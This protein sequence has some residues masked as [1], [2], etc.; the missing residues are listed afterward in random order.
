MGKE[1][2]LGFAMG[3]GVSLGIFSGIALTQAIKLVLLDRNKQGELA[4]ERVT[5]DVFSGASAGAMS[6]A[7]ML[8]GLLARDPNL[9]ATARARLVADYGAGFATL[10]PERQQDL[11]AAQV[12]QD[13]QFEVWARDINLDRLL[14]EGGRSLAF[15]PGLLDRKAV[16]AIAREHLS[17]SATTDM[18]TGHRLLADRVLFAC[19]L[20]NLTPIL[21]S[22]KQEYPGAA[23]GFIGLNDGLRSSIHRELRVFDLHLGELSA[24]TKMTVRDYPGRWCR[25]HL[26]NE[27]EGRIGDL[28]ANRTWA[29]IAATSIACGA[30]PGAFE[31]VVLDRADYEYGKLWPA[32][33]KEAKVDH[34]QFTYVDGGTFNNEPIREA[35]RMASFIDA[36]RRADEPDADFDRLIVFV[37]PF[38]SEEQQCFR[39]PVQQAWFLEEP[40]LFGSLDGVDLRRRSTLDRLVPHVG[41]LLGAVLNEARVVEADK[42]F[43]TSNRFELRSALRA[44]M[45]SVAA[46]DADNATLKELARH[47]KGELDHSA[48][49]SMIPAGRLNLAGE[50]RRVI[51]EEGGKDGVLR[52]L[53]DSACSPDDFEANPGSAPQAERGLWLRALSFIMLDL[54][55]DLE[56][57]WENYQLVAIAPFVDLKR[58]KHDGD[59]TEI[60]LPGAAFSGFAGFMSPLAGDFA[61]LAARYCAHEFLY[62]CRIIHSAPD[63]TQRPP[64]KLTGPQ[65]E[66]FQRDVERGVN[67]LAGR[68]EEVLKKSHLVTFF[69]GLDGIIKG[70]IASFVGKMVRKLKEDCGRTTTY[71]FRL[72]VWDDKTLEFDGRGVGNDLKPV[73]PAPEDSWQLITFAECDEQG[74]WHG[75]H[76]NAMQEIEVD[77]TGWASLNDRQFCRLQLPD[78]KART[79]A[80]L[81]GYPLFVIELT[82]DDQGRVF[83]G[84]DWELVPGTVPLE[85]TV[86]GPQP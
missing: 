33:L 9:E 69:P 23:E 35:F 36:Q 75:H 67:R 57:K 16:E 2:R 76:V 8:R 80:D 37:D 60:K 30:F 83:Q 34:H 66:Q 1:L 62:E 78:E 18:E 85:E 65:A 53:R 20:S 27:Q 82:T 4:Y 12:V 25:Y 11:V 44:K 50:L 47:I 43:Q 17:V 84:A 46:A 13:I 31:P 52:P 49:E 26:G 28:R 3:G 71:E 19:T 77:K 81:L 61:D 6:L 55:M 15:E 79:R 68:A 72:R 29:K 39:V 32:P 54:A 58:I 41:T 86:F 48:S 70:F 56:G 14:G 59:P 42:V 64:V 5:I 7:L 21:A 40:N 74:N 24:A 73:R 10:P 38:V 63:K 51:G 45:D 22:A